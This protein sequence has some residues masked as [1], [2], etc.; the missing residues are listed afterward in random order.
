MGLIERENLSILNE[1]DLC[2]G[3]ITWHRKTIAGEEKS[4]IDYILVCDF[5]LNY[6]ESMLIDELRTYVLTK[7]SKVRKI[8]SDHNVLY[9]KFAIQYSTVATKTKREIFDFKNY[10]SQNEFFEVTDS[11]TKLS[12]CFQSSTDFS[13]Q[14]NCFFKTLNRTFHQCFKKIRITNKTK[15][16]KNSESDDISVYFDLK[17]SLQLF[18]KSESC[19]LVFNKQLCQLEERLLRQLRIK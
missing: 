7:Y 1:N 8:E 18:S 2:E 4:V 19:K 14:A 12:S 15:K 9:A 6:L 11:T 16:K 10:D 3:V 5:L 13:N 17:T